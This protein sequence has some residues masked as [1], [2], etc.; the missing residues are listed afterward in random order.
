MQPHFPFVVPEPSYFEIWNSSSINSNVGKI[1]LKN[2]GHLT[3]YRVPL[4]C[5]WRG[6]SD[7]TLSTQLS[8]VMSS[9]TLCVLAILATLYETTV[10]FGIK[11][12]G[13]ETQANL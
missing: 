3:E 10:Q 1:T 12:I 9:V 13:A 8:T 2:R 11:V 5:S 4:N 6:E 7:N